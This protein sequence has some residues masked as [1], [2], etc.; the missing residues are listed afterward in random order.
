[1]MNSSPLPL[2]PNLGFCSFLVR[3]N[4][5]VFSYVF[6]VVCELHFELDNCLGDKHIMITLHVHCTIRF[7]FKIAY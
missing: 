7:G 2:A 3:K 4:L 5:N 6:D 1:M